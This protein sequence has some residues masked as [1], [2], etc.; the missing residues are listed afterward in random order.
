MQGIGGLAV[1]TDGVCVSCGRMPGRPYRRC[2]YC[3]EAVWHPFWRRAVSVSLVV[4]PPVLTALLVSM[5]QPDWAGTVQTL[6]TAPPA[7]GFLFAAGFGMLLL[8]CADSDLVVSSC[9]EQ[10]RWH[11]L[12]VGGG[13]LCGCYAALTAVCLCFGR[14]LEG[15]SW[16]LG[17]AVLACVASAPLFFRIPW[18]ALAAAAMIAAAIMLAP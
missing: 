17:G 14:R 9:A 6:R 1:C 3:G 4:V 10:A 2:P 12:A 5:T 13:L 7:I 8:P 16:L 11:A 15:S 18:R